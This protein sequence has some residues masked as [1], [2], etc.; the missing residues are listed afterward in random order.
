LTRKF[1]QRLWPKEHF[2]GIPKHTLPTQIANAVYDL[3]GT[4]STV[5]QI[6]TV[7]NEVGRS[8]SQIG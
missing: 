2:I 3:H 6:A 4:G 7:K 5:S 1:L 8:L